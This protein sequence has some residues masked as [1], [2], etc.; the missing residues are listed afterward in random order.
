MRIPVAT[1]RVQFNQDFRFQDAT[2]IVPQLHRLGISHLYASPIF[3]ARAGSTHGYDVV[4]PNRLNPVLGSAVDFDELVNALHSRG[5]GLLADIVPN[6]MA[7]SRENRWWMDVLENGAASPYASYFG[8]NWS[9]ASAPLQDKIFLPILGS[10][11]GQVLE[12]GELKLTYDE[13]AFWLDYYAH[14]LPISP[15]SYDTIL[16]PDSEPL[17]NIHEFSLLMESLER[18]PSR[19]ATEW[20]A[21]EHRYREK[22]SIKQRLWQLF[23]DCEPVRAHIERALTRLNA[24]TPEAFDAL[25]EL[26]QEQPYRIAFWKV[27]TE[28]INYRRFFDV[29]DLIGMRVEDPTVF[30]ASHKLIF[31]LIRE[32]KVDGLRI[33]HIDGL[34]DPLGYQKRLPTDDVY[35]VA[36]KILVGA[37]ELPDEWP[38]QGTT[39]YDFLGN[40]NS[41]F[42]EPAG[43]DK[44]TTYYQ[45]LT[46]SARVFRRR[47]IRTE[48]ARYRN[49]IS[50]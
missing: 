33:D 31:E 22:D 24:K 40:V 45:Q 5:M 42:V 10:P 9:S 6:H 12:A 41:L 8:I 3:E 28:R 2:A 14:R 39:G 43:L 38:V 46:G 48:E 27:A 30:E 32:R 34:A 37:E 20:E 26:I 23:H 25:D 44:L 13:G 1:Y 36:E 11:Y 17:V 4:D 35:V 49:A 7:A 19:E 15:I 50:W 18:L 16:R 29:S 47:R 21:L